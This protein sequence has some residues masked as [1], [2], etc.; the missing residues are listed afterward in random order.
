MADII[1]SIRESFAEEAAHSPLL[2]GDLASLERYVSESY[3][4]RSL[5]ELLQNAD[6]A[7]ARRFYVKSLGGHRFI[8]A[9]DG[10][11][12]TAD[13]VMALCRSGASTKSRH[14]GTIGYRGIGFKSVVNYANAV[15]LVSGETR[16][17]FSREL[18]SDLLGVHSVPLVRIPHDYHGD[19]FEHEVDACRNS[20]FVTVFIFESNSDALIDEVDAFDE[21]C[22][23][24]LHH[25]QA[26]VFER[27]ARGAVNHLAVRAPH[28]AGA[29][30]VSISGDSSPEDW[31]VH[32]GSDHERSE[33]IAFRLQ[34]D[35]VV[36]LPWGESVVH[37]FM[38]TQDRLRFPVRI[39]GDFST[40]P[41]RT[42]VVMDSETDEAVHHCAELL[43]RIVVEI[44]DAGNDRLK[45]L[46]ALA[47]VA[48]DP[49]A[50]VR[51][52]SVSDALFSSVSTLVLDYLERSSAALGVSRTVVQPDWINEGAFEAVCNA[53]RIHGLGTTLNRTVP[54]ASQFL[55]ALGVPLLTED[56]CLDA[57]VH[58]ILPESARAAVLARVIQRARFGMSE[59][60]RHAIIKAHLVTFENGIIPIAE[61]DSLAI[62]ASTFVDALRAI[63]TDDADV[64][65]FF[66]AV[67]LTAAAS[68][69]QTTSVPAPESPRSQ[70][71]FS[72][73]N[74][75]KKWRS[76]EKNV[77][78]IFEAV[79]DAV[80]VD[81]VSE[82]NL[83]YD[84]VATYLDGSKMFVEVKSVGSL[85]DTIS[86]TNNEY[87]TA[88]QEGDR[89][90]LAIAEQNSD[91]IVVCLVMN[92][93]KSLRFQKRVTRWE[94][95]CNEY[96]GQKVESPL[97][98]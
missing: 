78:A 61:A 13:D 47:E 84:I 17:T 38:P 87:S 36:R 5:I 53:L 50:S 82:Q 54:Q 67:G 10:R 79:D 52:K 51:G 23:L 86:V 63:V 30:R 64:Q 69:A 71:F 65:W 80:R 77:A 75:T 29:S 70:Q 48:P 81:D 14:A 39:N 34:G 6:D 90:C 83:G 60:L 68:Q 40:D 43:G 91:S 56:E 66:G 94:W 92:P 44:L 22:L 74:S 2:L 95:I 41:S 1:A 35:E 59:D 32:P 15:H 76:V 55:Q 21:S 20:G 28:G 58:E 98:E 12:F 46:K 49:L 25:I 31:L 27:G 8:V 26:T 3:T 18:T 72:K 97:A 62:P 11:P 9:N 37:S 89:Y 96:S 45:V 57:M 16:L 7:E 4:G 85:G 19:A 42:R 24:F 33:A 73:P 93:S 88:V